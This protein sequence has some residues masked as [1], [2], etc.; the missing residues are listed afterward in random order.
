[1]KCKDIIAKIEEKYPVSFAESW[2]NS[3]FLAGDASWE[4]RKVFLAL[5]ATDEVIDAAIECEADMII[6]H[7][8]LIFAGMKRVTADDFIGR[9]IIK[10]LQ[11]NIC[12]YAMHTNFDVLGMAEL[13]ADYLQLS[14]R[15]VLEITY[16]D[17]MN[18]EGIGRCGKLTT[19]MTLEECGKF[20]KEQLHLPF[21]QIYG[22][23]NKVIENLAVCTGSGKSLIKQVLKK[24]AQAYV[25]GD[26]DYHSSIDAVAQGI[27][28]IDAGH[29]GT[30]YIFMDYMERELKE[31]LPDLEV[32]K[33]HVS[34]PCK[35]IG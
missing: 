14:N 25:T 34:Y 8:P 20:V 28:I 29:Y 2:D 32:E 18:R 10:M 33:M 31:M 9:R 11:N 19:P 7:H 17:N 27:C 3:G 6:T 1:M 30:E 24:G 22:D 13:S 23:E 4:V 35:I 16:E 5:D 15:E 12:Y 26:M 21:V